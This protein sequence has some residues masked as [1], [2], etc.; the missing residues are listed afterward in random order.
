MLES[1]KVKSLKEIAER[2][3]LDNSYMSRMAD[4]TALAPDIVAGILD[5]SL[6]NQ[7]TLFDLGVDPSALW[8]EQRKRPNRF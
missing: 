3:K 2:W 6:P 5:D 8:E 4:L 1:G 7:I